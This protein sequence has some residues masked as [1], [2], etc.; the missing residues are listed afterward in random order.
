MLSEKFTEVVNLFQS[1]DGM[2]KAA[3]SFWGLCVALF[4]GTVIYII[5]SFLKAAILKLKGVKV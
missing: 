4:Y 2:E 3:F 5:F 1:L